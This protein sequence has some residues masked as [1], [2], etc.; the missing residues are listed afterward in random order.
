MRI[1]PCE[2]FLFILASDFFTCHRILTWG[3]WLYFPF[4]GKHPADFIA[5]KNPLPST[6]F[7]PANVGS[8][9]KHA[10]HYNTEA[11]TN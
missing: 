5:L 7:E 6:R 10:N 2:V 8:N 3:L 9:G 4:E 11:T 1:W